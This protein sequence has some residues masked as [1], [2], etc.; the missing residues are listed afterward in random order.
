MQKKAPMGP[1][2]LLKVCNG[3]FFDGLGLTAVIYLIGESY[4][5]RGNEAPMFLWLI[6][7]AGFLSL[8]RGLQIASLRLCCPY[9]GASLMAGG[10][11]PSSLPHFCPD[12]GKSLDDCD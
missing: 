2:K 8:F 4:Q 5:W 1:H 11:M 6:A 12:C 10:R 9:C 3:F 7:G